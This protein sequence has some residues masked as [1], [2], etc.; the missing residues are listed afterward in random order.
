[1]NTIRVLIG[2]WLGLLSFLTLASTT[3]EAD[4]RGLLVGDLYSIVTDTTKTQEFLSFVKKHK[5]TELTFYTGGPV[6]TRVIPTKQPEFKALLDK[7]RSQGVTFVSIAVGGKNEMDRITAFLTTHSV[8]ID[9]LWLEYEWWNNKPRDFDSNAVE[10]LKYMRYKSAPGTVIGAYIGWTEQAEMNVLLK[11]VDRV[12]I[13]SYVDRGSKLYP[14]MKTRLAQIQA[15][16]PEY[17]VKVIPI[18]SAEWLPPAICNQGPTAPGYYDNMCFLGPWLKA[19]NAFSGAESSFKDSE[20]SDRP[21]E[22]GVKTWRNF[23]KIAGFYYFS[24]KHCVDALK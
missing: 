7:V 23:A 2:V 5:F 21:T 19:N 24:Y 4:M 13:H 11:I 16:A 1:M 3:G 9:G 8:K 10:L 20:K 6:D 22:S 14:Q 18:I 15:A 17:P 12:Y